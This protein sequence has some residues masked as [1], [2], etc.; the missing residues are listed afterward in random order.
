M[1]ISANSSGVVAGKFTIPAGVPAGAK[2]VVFNGAGG[3]FGAAV[4]VGQG[5]IIDQTKRTVIKQTVTYYDPLAQTFVLPNNSQIS[6]ID[7]WFSAVGASEIEVQLRETSNG[8]PTQTMIASATVQASG[9]STSGSTRFTFDSPVT[10]LANTEYALVV[11]CNDAT[12]AAWVAVLG[13]WDSVN[14]H[15]VTSQ[16]FQV[17]VLLSSSD[18]S[19]WTAHQDRDLAFVLQKAVYTS[20]TQS[21]SLGTVSVTGATDLLL[22]ASESDP[23]STTGIEYTLTMPDTSTITVSNGQPVRLAAAVTG[24][25]AISAALTG[26]SSTS[27]ILFPGTQLVVGTVETSGEYVSRAIPGGSPCRVKVVLDAIIP[28]GAAVNV[29]YKATSGSTWSSVPF[30]SSTPT[31]NGFQTMIYQAPSVTASMLQIKLQLTGTAAARPRVK[32]LK[33]M[34]I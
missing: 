10:L 26:D 22:L 30:V 23:S 18:N 33:F 7:L 15:W 28:S 9:V 16:P 4:F 25:I 8:F 27:P 12:A 13:Q 31:D 32:N 20:N 5:T 34:T 21:V 2:Q 14:S 17:G 19:T 24:N 29:L 1:T 11:M 3:S 6:A